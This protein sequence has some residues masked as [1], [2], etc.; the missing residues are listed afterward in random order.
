VLGSYRCG[1]VKRISKVK[2]VGFLCG[3]AKKLSAL[4][5]FR[6]GAVLSCNPYGAGLSKHNK[7]KVAGSCAGC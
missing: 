6:A 7:V 3:G 2:V 4:C 1:K 5:G